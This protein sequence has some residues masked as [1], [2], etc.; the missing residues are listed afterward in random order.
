[1][2]FSIIGVQPHYFDNVYTYIL[3]LPEY[4]VTIYTICKFR[5]E[6]YLR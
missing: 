2:W 6:K 3:F 1:M 5:M 4:F